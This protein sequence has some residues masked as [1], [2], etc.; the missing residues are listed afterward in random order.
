[1]VVGVIGLAVGICVTGA[2]VASESHTDVTRLFAHGIRLLVPIGVAFALIGAV[3]GSLG[4]A[5]AS[6]AC[7]V[8][9]CRVP[10]Y[11]WALLVAVHAL[12]FALAWIA[13]GA[14]KDR[15][16]GT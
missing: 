7:E 5:V 6:R 2:I 4:T 1:L 13:V 12:W 8:P 16:P 9:A 15:L 11:I 3:A 14:M 10:R